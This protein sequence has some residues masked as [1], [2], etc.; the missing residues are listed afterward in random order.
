LDGFN[1]GFGLLFFLGFGLDDGTGRGEGLN[2]TGLGAGGLETG[3]TT[4]TSFTRSISFI[5]ESNLSFFSIGFI[6]SG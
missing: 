5:G 4:G 6:I 3:L 1:L 2:M